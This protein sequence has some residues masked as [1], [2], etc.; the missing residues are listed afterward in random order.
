MKVAVRIGLA[1]WMLGGLLVPSLAQDDP[2]ADTQ[3]AANAAAAPEADADKAAEEKP[4]EDDA[5]K[6][7]EQKTSAPAT[8]TVK[9]ERLR[10]RVELDG[11]FESTE[12]AEVSIAPKS[13]SEL[14]VAKAVEQGTQVRRGEPIIWL[15]TEKLERQIADLKADRELSDLSR[16]QAENEI[17]LL[18]ETLPLQLEAAQR[19]LQTA[20]QDY[21]YFQEAKQDLQKRSAEQR[22][23]SAEHQLK[24]TREELDQLEKMYG[25]EDLTEGTEEIILERARFMVKQSEFSRE[26]AGVQHAEALKF[27]LPRN[28]DQ[29][30]DAA[31]QARL[32]L[33]RAQSTLPSELRH[34]QLELDKLDYEQQ[35]K[36]RNLQELEQD[37]ALMIITAPADGIIYYGA[38]KRGKWTTAAMADKL[39]PGGRISA[40]E[41]LMTV[42]DPAQLVVLATA[43]EKELTWLEPNQSATIRPTAFPKRWLSASVDQIATLP[44]DNITFDVRL[45]IT[46]DSTQRLMPGMTAKVN[47]VTY[48]QKEA[49]TVPAS[50]VFEDEDAD[51][52]AWYVFVD[53]DG[54]A[55]RQTVK[56]G[57][58]SEKRAEILEGLAAGDVVRTARPK[59]DEVQA[60]S[61]KQEAQE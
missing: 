18:K 38:A 25:A 23:D 60:P 48:D 21:E 43:P 16:K 34:K 27:E 57:R 24:F 35:K 28:K 17:R 32:A 41:V 31:E 3:P 33:D 6:K 55:E 10:I 56:V 30:R 12:A 47:V 49:L 4:A 45:R 13:W 53:R 59:E 29:L 44:N 40:H 50:A 52:P 54:K 19:K 9:A 5:Q 58:Q 2:A 42:I 22:V 14:V 61:A 15:E 39:R 26:M 8:A 37:R 1:L 20:T 36:D 7:T 46:G 11:V 51:E